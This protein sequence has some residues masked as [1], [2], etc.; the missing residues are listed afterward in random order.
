MRSGGGL[1]ST[2][3]VFDCLI[4]RFGLDA[5]VVGVCSATV[6]YVIDFATSEQPSVAD[7]QRGAN[8]EHRAAVEFR[9]QHPTRFHLCC[10]GS[11]PP[12]HTD[13]DALPPDQT[14][15]RPR[16]PQKHRA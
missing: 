14:H 15:E 8:L 5:L 1:P 10:H 3:P 4:Y 7:H 6:E 13:V 12:V 9:E 16:C 11:L 2:R